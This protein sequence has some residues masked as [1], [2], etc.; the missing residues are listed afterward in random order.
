MRG[1][2]P[3]PASS[4]SSIFWHPVTTL[5]CSL[6]NSLFPSR[7]IPLPIPISCC[8]LSF[9][10]S[11]KY[12]SSPCCYSQLSAVFFLYFPSKSLFTITGS[13]TTSKLLTP[14]SLF[15]PLDPPSR[16][17]HT[18]PTWLPTSFPPVESLKVQDAS[19]YTLPKLPPFPS[20]SKSVI[21]IPLIPSCPSHFITNQPSS[22][23]P[24]IITLL[25]SIPYFHAHLP[26]PKVRI[27]SLFI[28]LKLPPNWSPCP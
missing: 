14:K 5:K 25:S 20:L 22:H 13:T 6:P 2:C 10:L 21:N 19:N 9:L 26:L 23:M 1:S 7:I 24:L 27:L 17:G 4:S 15:P 11:L 8:L 16:Q 12:S 18:L 28:P 3:Q